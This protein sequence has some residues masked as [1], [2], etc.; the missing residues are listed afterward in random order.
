VYKI[1]IYELEE[2]RPVG[3]SGGRWEDNIKI[4]LNKIVVHYGFIWLREKCSGALL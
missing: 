1:L 3:M 2:K 4:D